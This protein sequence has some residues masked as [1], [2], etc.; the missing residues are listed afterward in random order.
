MAVFERNPYRREAL[1]KKL[2]GKTKAERVANFKAM[3][4][5]YEEHVAKVDQELAEAEIYQREVVSKNKSSRRRDFAKRRAK[6]GFND[7]GAEEVEDPQ[8][9]HL[10]YVQKKH[11]D[12]QRDI[13]ERPRIDLTEGGIRYTGADEC[14]GPHMP[15]EHERFKEV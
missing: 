13:R 4:Q 15:A 12:A 7:K 8:I 9:E 10:E 2:Y 3:S 14:I 1:I 5:G 6:L 11:S